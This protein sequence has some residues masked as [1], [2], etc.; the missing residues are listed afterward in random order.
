MLLSELR[1]KCKRG[2]K[3]WMVAAGL[4]LRVQVLDLISASGMLC[5]RIIGPG[6]KWQNIWQTEWQPPLY[7]HATDENA[8]TWFSTR[9]EAER[10]ALAVKIRST[11][12]QIGIYKKE[13]ARQKVALAN[14]RAKLNELKSKLR[15]A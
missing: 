7:V 11:E 2:A 10:Y 9:K 8:A 4:V 6:T 5:V 3:L 12:V 14:K 13:I 1:S 15:S